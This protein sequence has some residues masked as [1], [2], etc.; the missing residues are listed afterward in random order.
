MPDNLPTVS[1]SISKFH[2]TKDKNIDMVLNSSS[3]KITSSTTTATVHRKPADT[4]EKRFAN[5]SKNDQNSIENIAVDDNAQSFETSKK[6]I[7][8]E[9]STSAQLFKGTTPTH[10]SCRRNLHR[11]FKN[12][13]STRK[14]IYIF[15]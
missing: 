5:N 14:I 12:I 13:S 2:N 7:H 1:V 9:T 6:K 10:K 8:S 11:P 4:I 15:K 3:T